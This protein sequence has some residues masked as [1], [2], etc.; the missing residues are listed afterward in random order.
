MKRI[1]HYFILLLTLLF[2]TT[3]CEVV[4]WKTEHDQSSLKKEGFSKHQMTLTEGGQLTYWE[5]GQG[6]PL[7]LLHGFGGTAAATWKAEMIQLSKKYHVIA[8]DLLW[9]GESY[10]DNSA[11]LATQT[12]AIWQLVDKLKLNKIDVAGISYGGFITYDMMLTPERINKAVIIASPGPLFNDQDLNDLIKRAGIQ[13]PEELFVPNN[14]DDVKRLYDNVFISKK[15]IP[16]FI[17]NQ[18]YLDYFSQWKPQ[19][20]QLIKTLPNDRDR[21]QQYDPKKLPQTLLIWGENDQIFPLK[22]GIKLS[23]YIQAPIVVLPK[24]AHGITNEQ[25]AITANLIDN[26]LSTQ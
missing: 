14:G 26:F 18:I 11:Q 1:L 23:Q 13:S 16:D 15:I 4:R 24:T 22:S 10:S 20:T 21:I 9:F 6:Q 3:G 17:A 8:P 5:G 25:P 2:V 19:R 7:L 12:N